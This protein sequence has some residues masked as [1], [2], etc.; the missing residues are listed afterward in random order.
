VFSLEVVES[1]KNATAPQ[2]DAVLGFIYDSALQ[3]IEEG[4]S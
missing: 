3:R 2:N 1:Q 4:L